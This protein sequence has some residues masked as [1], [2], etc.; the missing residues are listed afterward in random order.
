MKIERLGRHVRLVCGG[1]L[2]VDV[3]AVGNDGAGLVTIRV[4]VNVRIFGGR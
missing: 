1:P 4:Y 2:L 3:K